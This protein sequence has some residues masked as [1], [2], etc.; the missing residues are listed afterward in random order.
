[1]VTPYLSKDIYMLYLLTHSCMIHDT[2][3]R[4]ILL[5]QKRTIIKLE[6]FDLFALEYG[7]SL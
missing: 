2:M 3:A 5:A 1:M 7:P 6:I 4:S